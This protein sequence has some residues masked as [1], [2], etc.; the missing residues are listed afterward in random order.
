ML[1]K[2]LE[3]KKTCPICRTKISNSLRIKAIST[4]EGCYI[5]NQKVNTHLVPELERMLAAGESLRDNN[6]LLGAIK[7]CM[8]DTMQ[9]I[10][11]FQYSNDSDE[12]ETL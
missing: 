7:Y 10:R 4:F 3:K 1:S 5:I 12:E 6:I 9:T 11:R 2:H 8:Y